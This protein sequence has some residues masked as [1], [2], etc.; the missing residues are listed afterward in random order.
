MAR[1]VRPAVAGAA[2][3]GGSATGGQAGSDGGNTGGT[4]GQAG[5]DDGG[6]GGTTTGG[7]GG[8]TTGGTGGTTTGGTGGTT[9]GGTGGTTTGGRRH[10][11]GSDAGTQCSTN[12]ECDNG[13]YCDGVEQCVSGQCTAGT[14]VQCAADAYSCTTAVCDEA[15]KTCKT[16]L[17][18]AACDDRLY[19]TGIEECDPANAPSGSTTGCKA[20]TPINCNDNVSC[21]VDACDETNNRL[22]AH[23]QQRRLQRRALLQRRRNLRSGHLG[24]QRHDRLRR[25]NSPRL[26]GRPGLHGGSCDET[27]DTCVACPE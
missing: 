6:T 5:A 13:I 19:C 21:T 17:S 18:D 23:E 24:R 14:P 2:G 22:H 7:T 12:A 26:P 11:T 25:R 8:T 3:S 16:S 20:G 1:A 27:N 4:S 10:G 9:T 15:S